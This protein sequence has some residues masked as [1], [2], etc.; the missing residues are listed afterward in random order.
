MK[1]IL[2]YVWMSDVTEQLKMKS[3]SSCRQWI[4]KQGFTFEKRRNPETSLVGLC[5]T[6]KQLDQL[7]Q[8]RQE[9]GFWGNDNESPEV[10]NGVFYLIQPVPEFS[11]CRVKLGFSTDVMSRIIPYK[12][13]CPNAK[14]VK[15][16]RCLEEWE[17]TA[18]DSVTRIECRQVGVEVFDCESIENLV[19]RIDSFFKLMPLL[20]EAQSNEG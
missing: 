16:W 9:C 7:K 12:T 20:S 8:I 19:D 5:L 17:K 4:L 11:L 14:V 2:D 18:I 1:N 15:T 6:Q 10:V 3:T 13:I